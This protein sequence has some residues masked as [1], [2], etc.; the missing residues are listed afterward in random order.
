VS[1]DTTS[2]LP[3]H[4]LDTSRHFST[5]LYT[6]STPPTPLTLRHFRAQPG[7]R[8]LAEALLSQHIDGVARAG[9]AGTKSGSNARSLVLLTM[10]CWC[11]S[12]RTARFEDQLRL[13][14]GA[15]FQIAGGY[16][17]SSSARHIS[18][19]WRSQLAVAVGELPASS[20]SAVQLVLE[21]MGLGQTP[22]V[23]RARA[24]ARGYF[25]LGARARA[26]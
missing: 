5:L 13:D 3:R 17:T 9:S 4:Y 12:S 26:S 25:T 11:P 18:S 19:P 6:A 10:A 7:C 15:N 14:D 2:T 1:I 20:V 24:R 22:P 16:A 21:T 8:F 23:A